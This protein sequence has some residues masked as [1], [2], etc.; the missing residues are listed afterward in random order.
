MYHHYFYHHPACGHSSLPLTQRS[1]SDAV[2]EQTTPTRA[3]PNCE[4]SC[5]MSPVRAAWVE[6]RVIHS[7]SRIRWRHTDNLVASV[8]RLLEPPIPWASTAAAARMKISTLLTVARDDGHM[9][10]ACLMAT[11]VTVTTLV[12][13]PEWLESASDD[14]WLS[15]WRLLP[16]ENDISAIWD[17]RYGE[18]DISILAMQTSE[19]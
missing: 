19:A 13:N 6:R 16:G 14:K 2:H 8:E 4:Q 9:S 7:R 18:A 12:R 5:A 11:L 3:L 10:C 17:Q 15:S 1:Y